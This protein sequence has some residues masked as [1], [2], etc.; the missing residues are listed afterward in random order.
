[1]P[2]LATVGGRVLWMSRF[3][4]SLAGE[5]Q[6]EKL[7]I[8][9]Y[10]S[11]RRFLA[12]TLN[13]YYLAINRLREGGVSR[14]Q[15]SFTHASHTD[16]GLA[17]RRLLIGVHFTSPTERDALPAVSDALGT[18]GCELVYATR[19]TATLG[20]LDPPRDTDPNPLALKE[21]ALFAPAGDELPV[22][23]FGAVADE[24]AALTDGC[25][26]QTYRREPRSAYRPSFRPVPQVT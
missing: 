25:S 14:F 8:V 9:R 10:P 6:A 23:D 21:L 16:P 12:M 19:E 20:F 26:L 17:G 11:H 5:Q 15:A 1:M 24:L 18:A 2:A 3:E 4:R 22:A 13:P 7:L